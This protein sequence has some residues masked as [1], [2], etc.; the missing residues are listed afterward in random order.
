MPLF[1]STYVN[2]VDKKGRVSVPARYRAQLAKHNFSSVILF[3]SYTQP[4]IEGCGEDFMAEMQ[5][6]LGAFD[7]FAEETDDLATSIMSDSIEQTFDSEGR[8]VLPDDLLK[9]AGITDSAAFVG[10]GDRFQIWEPGAAERYKTAARQR[11]MSLRGQLASRP[12]GK[13]DS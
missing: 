13:G 9:H 6:R 3:P 12:A 5:S 10:R 2:K 7:P 4:A 1:L 11:A 8:I